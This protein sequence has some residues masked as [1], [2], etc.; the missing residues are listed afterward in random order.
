MCSCETEKIIL[1]HWDALLQGA[2]KIAARCI[3]NMLG[4][5]RPSQCSHVF[6]FVIILYNVVPVVT[7]GADWVSRC[8]KYKIMVENRRKGS[9]AVRRDDIFLHS[10]GQIKKDMIPFFPLFIR[11][12]L[13]L[14]DIPSGASEKIFS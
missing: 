3:F 5:Q 10:L 4:S 11:G 6:G 14:L 8:H 2:P 1:F 13:L 9:R 7:L 12:S